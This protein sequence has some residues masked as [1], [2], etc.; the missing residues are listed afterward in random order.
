[1]HADGSKI[2]RVIRHQQTDEGVVKNI[3]SVPGKIGPE[4]LQQFPEITD[5]MRVTHFGSITMGNDPLLRDYEELNVVDSTFF[6]FFDFKLL[7]GNPKTALTHPNGIVISQKI[8][9]K[10]LNTVD[11]LGKVIWANDNDL[12]ISG[13]ME[14]FPTNSHLQLDILFTQS[15]VETYFPFH[16]RVRS[17]DWDTNS[18]ATYLKVESNDI[19]GIEN[20]MTQ[21]VASNYPPDREFKSTSFQ[22]SRSVMC[23]FIPVTS[24]IIK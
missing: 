12:F 5:A 24:R 7:Q 8:A 10:Y 3:A 18:T 22:C 6:D 16:S 23:T 15:A 9:L 2:H 17:N 13:V 11:A 4:S 21:L 20:K 19:T 1:M 14:N